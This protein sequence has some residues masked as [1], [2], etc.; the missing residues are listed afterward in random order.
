MRTVYFKYSVPQKTAEY[1]KCAASTRKLNHCS[2]VQD[3]HV[4]YE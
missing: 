3:H 2:S 1:P 4:Y